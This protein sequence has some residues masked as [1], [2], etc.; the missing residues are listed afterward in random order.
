MAKLSEFE[1]ARYKKIASE[2]LRL[3]EEFDELVAGQYAAKELRLEELPIAGTFVV[4]AFED[5][6]YEMESL[7][8][9]FT[10]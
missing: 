7:D 4:D 5:A 9:A 2:F 1:I 6:G 3:Y 10:E 8:D